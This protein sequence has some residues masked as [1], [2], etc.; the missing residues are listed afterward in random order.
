MN[1]NS[2]MSSDTLGVTGDLQFVNLRGDDVENFIEN[3]CNKNTM[4]K[5]Y[6]DILPVKKFLNIKNETR[7]FKDYFQ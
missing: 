1:C 5:T 4:K 6:N 2:E 7:D 3:P